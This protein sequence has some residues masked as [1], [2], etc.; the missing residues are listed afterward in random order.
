MKAAF[1]HTAE[2]RLF[3]EPPRHSPRSVTRHHRPS[4][5]LPFR[6]AMFPSFR[7]IVCYT[8]SLNARIA[9]LTPPTRLRPPPTPPPSTSRSCPFRW[10]KSTTFSYTRCMW[11]VPTQSCVPKRSI[12]FV[13]VHRRSTIE[14]TQSY[15]RQTYTHCQNERLD[16]EYACRL[17]HSVLSDAEG[18]VPAGGPA[19]CPSAGP[20]HTCLQCCSRGALELLTMPGFGRHSWLT[21]SSHTAAGVARVV[22]RS[23]S[24]AKLTPS[25]THV[26]I[27]ANSYITSHRRRPSPLL[28][29]LRSRHTTRRPRPTRWW[30][31]AAISSSLRRDVG[32][33]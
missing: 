22:T 18:H 4:I 11:T 7:T 26:R 31:L 27:T 25:P 5:L 29:T 13:D 12:C 24:L 32:T 9:T 3:A 16:S 21:F 10:L 2:M 19:Y 23:P 14:L 28:Q 1:L 17:W 20:E 30:T 8:T 6:A 33:Q 15:I